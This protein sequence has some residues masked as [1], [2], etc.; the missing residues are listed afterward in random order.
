VN[1]CAWI[2]NT[3]AGKVAC[4]LALATPDGC[5]NIDVPA[6]SR[7]QSLPDPL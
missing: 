4:G 1:Q 5:A 3:C 2:L 7:L 6:D